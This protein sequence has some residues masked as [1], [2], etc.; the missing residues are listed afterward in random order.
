M[1]TV[2]TKSEASG[3]DVGESGILLEGVP[4]SGYEA[5]LRWTRERRFRITYDW[6]TLEIISPSSTHEEQKKLMAAMIEILMEECDIGYRSLGSM[7]FKRK[8]LRRGLEPD[9]CY[10]V[11]TFAEV[12]GRK[13]INL[14][15]DPP[16]DLVLEVD[17]SS[18][19]VRR[20]EIYA[21]LGVSEVVIHRD[22]AIGFLRLGRDGA[23]RA[24][25]RLCNFPGFISAEL[26]EWLERGVGGAHGSWRKA[27]RA[28]VRKRIDEPAGR[29]RGRKSH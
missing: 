6:G 2:V 8:D 12:S 7:T 21:S 25:P 13:K 23:Y 18:S 24:V 28:L 1:A 29:G 10:Y 20:L 15:T 27:F 14:K 22:G 19:S 3:A 11:E 4:W 26:T 5:V 9:D 16:P 17:V